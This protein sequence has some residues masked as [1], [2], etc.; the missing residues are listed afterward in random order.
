MLRFLARAPKP[1]A[2]WLGFVLLLAM[3]VSAVRAGPVDGESVRMV[4][5]GQGAF[6]QIGPNRWAEV[7]EAT[8]KVILTARNASDV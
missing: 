6:V 1:V 5:Y 2:V 4:D 3:A 8:G 7:K